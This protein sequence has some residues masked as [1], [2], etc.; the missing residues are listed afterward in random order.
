MSFST[1]RPSRM[2]RP[3]DPHTAADSP[4]PDRYAHKGQI[5]AG[6]LAV[7]RITAK[8]TPEILAVMHITDKQ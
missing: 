4:A 6:L 1:A 3:L 2:R 8:S 7:M 5:W